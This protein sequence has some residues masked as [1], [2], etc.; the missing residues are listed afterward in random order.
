MTDLDDFLRRHKEEMERM[1]KL[2]RMN[3]VAIILI[4]A[5]GAVV[6]CGS[7]LLLMA[8]AFGVLP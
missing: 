1:D 2:R 3:M 4:F 5:M 6:V 8:V 7:S